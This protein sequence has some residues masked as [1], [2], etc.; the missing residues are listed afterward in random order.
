MDVLTHPFGLQLP[1]PLTDAEL[2]WLSEH[3]EGIGFE[4]SADGELILSPPTGGLGNLGEGK[5]FSQVLTWNEQVKFGVVMGLTGGVHP[6]RGGKYS[7]DTTLISRD[8]WN[9]VPTERRNDGFVPVL[10]AAVFELISPGDLTATGYTAEFGNKLEDYERSAI[11]LVVRLHP[12][13]ESATLRRPGH[14]ELTTM[15]IL[16]FEELPG[17]KLDAGTIYA[18]VNTP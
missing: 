4:Q 14:D 11:P 9:A 6:P 16:T 2:L 5:L 12:K 18:A 17:L 3:N 7:P 15:K 1:A 8:S 10:P 13:T